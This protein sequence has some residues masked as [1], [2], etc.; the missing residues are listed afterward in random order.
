MIQ[1]SPVGRFR[2]VPALLVFVA[3]F[4][5]APAGLSAQPASAQEAVDLYGSAWREPDEAKRRAI[6]EK[7]WAEDGVYTDPTA[8]VDGREALVQHIGGFLAELS[9]GGGPSL[10]IDSSVDAHHDRFLRFAWKVV[11]ADGKTVV[12]PGM[13][14]GELDEDGRLKLIVGFFGPFPPVTESP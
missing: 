8:Y 6:L 9:A 2:I 10:Q 11:A 1:L 7:A 12:S 3:V 13:D 5:L 4:A 14:Y